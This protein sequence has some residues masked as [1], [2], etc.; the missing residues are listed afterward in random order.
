RQGKTIGFVPT[1]GYLHQ[2]HLSL[3]R[4][5]RAENDLLVVSIFVNP[6]Q[7]APGED[8]KRYPRDFSRD[9]KM[10][11]LCGTDVIFFPRAKAMYRR[12]CK[13]YVDVEELSELL[14]G[15]SR[16][17][18][19]RGVTTVVAKLFNIVQPDIAYLGQKDAQ[20]AAIIKQM[21]QDL[22]FPLKIKILP[23]VRGQGGLALSSRN[24]YLDENQKKAAQILYKALQT[25]V[26]MIKSGHYAP[27]EIIAKMRGMIQAKPGARIDYIEIL[28]GKSL[29]K[30]KKL[31]GPLLIA[32]AVYFGKTRLI[33][34]ALAKV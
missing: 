24:S 11:R 30:A 7:F 23:I 6:T 26:G 21:S 22:N 15:R 13:T 4:R 27:R 2:G 31:K 34:N 33:D 12:D 10:A 8:F 1:M 16:P 3:M 14:C 9:K 32:L 17:T 20:Q 29:K 28:E 19:F 25:A 5:A 18:H